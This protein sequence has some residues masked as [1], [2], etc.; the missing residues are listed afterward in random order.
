MSWFEQLRQRLHDAPHPTKAED[1]LRAAAVLLLELARADAE[2]HPAELATLRAGLAS[3][4]AVPEATLDALLAD[5]DAQ[6][7]ASVSLFDFVQTLN[8]AMS[9]DEK[10]ALLDLLWRVA[11]ADG[12]I[13]SNEEHLLR[14][15]SDML[16]L[17]HG[18]YI[19]AKH[20]G[21]HL[22]GKG[23]D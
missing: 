15:L 14:R 6:A 8:R 23:H 20:A 17:S 10:R 13:E 9:Q 7:K 16:H 12:K 4:F 22:L 1:R 2:H 3:E 5:A 19:R 18:D 11:Y 21:Q